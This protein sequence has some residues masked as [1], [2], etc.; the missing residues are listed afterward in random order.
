MGK[1]V[2]NQ[3]WVKTYAWVRP[4]GDKCKALCCK[5]IDIGM[6]GESV[7]KSHRK[8]QKHQR[9]ERYQ[10]ENIL[11]LTDC[12]IKPEKSSTDGLSTVIYINIPPPTGSMAVKGT[13]MAYIMKNTVLRTE[14][15]W[16]LQTVYTFLIQVI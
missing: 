8:S 12:F 15:L 5:E 14:V 1:C 13:L 6:M 2:F 11:K 16:T 3:L 10:H 9:I 4:T 7:L